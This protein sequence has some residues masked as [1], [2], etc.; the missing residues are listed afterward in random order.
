MENRELIRQAKMLALLEEQEAKKRQ[1]EE[2]MER[3]KEQEEKMAAIQAEE[4]K[5]KEEVEEEE[6]RPLERRRGGG[7]TSK[8]AE[9]VE[10]AQE[11]A[12]HLELG[13]DQEAKMAV[14]E[15]ERE[16]ARRQIEAERDPVK[17]VAKEEEQR[18][19][20]RYR[21]S[22]ERV[23]RLEAAE[24]ADKDLRA[25]EVRMGKIRAE[26]E[27][28]TKLDTL[29]QSV[30]ALLV[31]QREQMQYER[32]QDIKIDAIRAGF[33]DFTCD[34]MNHLLTEE[35]IAI[36]RNREF[37]TGAIEG[38]KLAAPKKRSRPHHVA[39]KSRFVV[40]YLDDILVFSKTLEEHEGHL[41]QIL[42]KLRESNFK[43][44]PKKCEWAK[45]QV[46]YLG[47]V[48]DDDGIGP[49]D[50]KIASI[51]DW[52]TPK[53]LTE[54]RSFLG[55]ANYYRKFVRNFSTIAAPLRRLLKKEAIWKWD[56]DCT[57]DFKKLKNAL[58]EY[59]V[60]K[61]VD[62]SLPFAVTTDASQYGIGVVM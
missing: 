4:E 1:M 50:N 29:I 16:A 2:E 55:L 10:R 61:V 3:W 32:S 52:P 49:E 51:R 22:Q 12:A 5:E 9:I 19:A 28:A 53:T 56:Q 43:I 46:L 7:S 58:I 21:L 59:P 31:A 35:H 45:T 42:S 13:E 47:H 62:P 11:W 57:S 30:E 23:R 54:L 6:E 44:N 26:T 36:N 24:R 25:V 20:S 18:M 15:E 40:V 8:D 34:M 48:L 14:P 38:A 60:L 17:R 37:C 27:L 39:R 41:R 33:K